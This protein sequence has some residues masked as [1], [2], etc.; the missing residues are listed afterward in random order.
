MKWM[1]Y[2]GSDSKLPTQAESKTFQHAVAK[3]F[4]RSAGV[5]TMIVFIDICIDIKLDRLCSGERY[6]K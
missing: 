5:N 3:A 1:S 2:L 4:L 6:F